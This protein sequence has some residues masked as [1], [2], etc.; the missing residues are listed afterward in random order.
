MSDFTIEFESWD[1]Y[2]AYIKEA[3]AEELHALLLEHAKCWSEKICDMERA[4]IEEFTDLHEAIV[5]KVVGAKNVDTQTLSLALESGSADGEWANM[6]SYAVMYSPAIDKEILLKTPA[7]D[8]EQAWWIMNHD[9]ADIEV[10]KNL[11]ST[12]GYS[13][14]DTVSRL[15]YAEQTDEVDLYLTGKKPKE[16]GTPEREAELLEKIYAKTNGPEGLE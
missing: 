15:L 13:V 8:H 9:L 10:I 4:F 12:H 5:I 3:T 11:A 14:R 16:Y 7:Y 6:L 2:N 1:E